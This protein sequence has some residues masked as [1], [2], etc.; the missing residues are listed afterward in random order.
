MSFPQ[1][2]APRSPR[3]MG[4]AAHMQTVGNGE[5]ISRPKIFACARTTHLFF[6]A[7]EELGDDDQGS[8][9]NECYTCGGKGHWAR[10]VCNVALKVAEQA[11]RQK[12]SAASSPASC[13]AAFIVCCTRRAM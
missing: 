9:T 10:E 13:I 12:K 1:L 2:K 3:T 5:W 8:S 7:D 6:Q 4:Y 11:P